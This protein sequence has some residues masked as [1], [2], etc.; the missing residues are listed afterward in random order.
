[1]LVVGAVQALPQVASLLLCVATTIATTATRAPPAITKRLG[2]PPWAW[3]TPAGFPAA[4]PASAAIAGEPAKAAAIAI[5]TVIV[6][7]F[8]IF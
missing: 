7:N 3:A 5:A 8:A 1:V 6:P 4:S 2:D